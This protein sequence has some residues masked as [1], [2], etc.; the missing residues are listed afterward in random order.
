MRPVHIL[1]SAVLAS[2]LLASGAAVAQQ[3]HATLAKPAATPARLGSFDDWTAATHQEGGQKVCYAFA[4]PQNST[5]VLPGRS[6]VVL[7]VTERP[8]GRDAVAL[9]AGF[10]FATGAEPTM[11]I[12]QSGHPLYTSGRSAFARDGAAVVAAMKTGRSVV[13]RSP[14]PTKAQ[15]VDTFSLKGFAPAYAAIVKACPATK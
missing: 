8:I 3:K 14:G 15:I 13:V 7:T 12:D 5:P 6:E 10:A 4:R 1:A 2:S 11:Q 9:S